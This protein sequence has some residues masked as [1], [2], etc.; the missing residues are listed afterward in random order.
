MCSRDPVRSVP[1]VTWVRGWSFTALSAAIAAL[2][3]AFLLGGSPAAWG[4]SDVAHAAG[5]KAKRT[6]V[7]KKKRHAAVRCK[8]R[9]GHH[10]SSPAPRTVTLT[11]DSS[12]DIDLQIYDVHRRHAGLAGGI[13]V[14][15]FPGATHSGNDADG[16]GPETF[17]DPQGRRVGYLVCYVS[18]PQANVTLI[19]SGR[20]GGR[21]TATLGP[22]G[23]PPDP[24]QPYNTSVGWGFLPIGARC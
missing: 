6:K 24:T 9:K 2:G 13:L 15:D 20:Q 16:F 17:T 11:W 8:K 7:C 21:Y 4:A 1:P 3:C 19:D 23:S 5:S 18:G 14:N 12:A 10:A 22:A